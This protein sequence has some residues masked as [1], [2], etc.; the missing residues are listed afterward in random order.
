MIFKRQ[1]EELLR[2]AKPLRGSSADIGR[3]S[4]LL[5]YP[6]R[7]NRTVG[8]AVAENENVERVFVFGG[9]L[10]CAGV[11]IARRLCIGFR[12]DKEGERNNGREDNR[13]KK[14]TAN[15]FVEDILFH[16]APSLKTGVHR[17]N[18]NIIRTVCA[19]NK[20]EHDE[21]INY[22]PTNKNVLF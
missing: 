1:A 20:D 10:H 16:F 19:E 8:K 17:V 6:E 21:R 11:F 4:A 7:A 15:N 3:D 12:A 14:E 9:H 13:D 2:I 22:D 18:G 5:P